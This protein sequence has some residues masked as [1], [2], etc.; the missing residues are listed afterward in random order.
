[1]VNINEKGVWTADGNGVGENV[2]KNSNIFRTGTFASGITGFVNSDGEYVVTASSGNSNWNSS[3]YASDALV[4]IEDSFLEGDTFTVSFLIKSYDA[5]VTTPP[6]IYIKSGMGYYQLLGQ[7][8][9]D[10][11]IVYYTGTWKKANSVSPHIGWSG[12]IGT[13]YIKQWKIEKGSIVTP[14]IP[15]S[16]DDIYVSNSVGFSEEGDKT[17]IW[18]CGSVTGNEFIQF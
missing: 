2:V 6:D 16:A 5:N 7:V 18:S 14:W 15:N 12:L 10:Y 9:K 11:S 3:W 13:Y 17:K 1:M 8:N 4:G